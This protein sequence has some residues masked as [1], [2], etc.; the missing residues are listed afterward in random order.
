MFDSGNDERGRVRG[1]SVVN[2][3]EKKTDIL[4]F[5]KEVSVLEAQSVRSRI[6]QFK[7]KILEL[8][9]EHSHSNRSGIPTS[10]FHYTTTS[11]MNGILNDGT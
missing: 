9:F 2:I 8:S 6:L 3:E 4:N 7:A 5:C 10:L 1:L 11:G